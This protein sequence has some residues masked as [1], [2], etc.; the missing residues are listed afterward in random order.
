MIVPLE[1]SAERR[2]VL[3]ASSSRSDLLT[4]QDLRF[5]EAVSHWV[6]IAIHRAELVEQQTKEERARAEDV[7]GYLAAIV[8]SS[9]D[10]II[11]KDLSGAIISWNAAAERMYGYT[12]RQIVGQSITLLFPPD[13][14]WE[15]TQIMERIGRGERVEPFETIR[16]RKDGTLCT[17]P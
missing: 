4:G 8:S 1:V 5:L 14:Q 10:A 7:L 16:M 13:R 17:F 12:E 2:G 11:G 3:F 15:F 6:G 9:S